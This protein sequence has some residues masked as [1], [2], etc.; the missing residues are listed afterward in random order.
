MLAYRFPL[1]LAAVFSAFSLI[2]PIAL[3]Q[4]F[5]DDFEDNDLVDGLPVNWTGDFVDSGAVTASN[6]DMVLTPVPGQLYT[7][8]LADA[9]H[10]DARVELKYEAPVDRNI[11]LATGLRETRNGTDEGYWGGIFATG[12]LAI[13]YVLPSGPVIVQRNVFL[14]SGPIAAGN[15]IT[16]QLEAIGNDITVSAWETVRGSASAASISW[17]DPLDRYPTGNLVYPSI[18]PNGSSEAV[19]LRSFRMTAIP[20]PS[21]AGLF[22]VTALLAVRRG[23]G[24]R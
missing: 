4:S 6:G 8:P 17:T 23:R 7:I 13:G 3:A 19:R 9:V 14:P 10:S 21:S 2:Q 16:L 24:P 20:E 12:E 1:M 22:V 11:F 18:T 15:E 5:F